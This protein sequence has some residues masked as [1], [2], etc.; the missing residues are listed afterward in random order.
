MKKNTGIWLDFKEAVIIDLE[1]GKEPAVQTL[2]SGVDTSIAKGGAGTKGKPWGPMD[3]ISENQHL[4]RRKNQESKYFQNVM[5]AVQASSELY[6]F[7]PAEAK[8][9]LLKAIKENKNFRPH[10]SAVETAD[11]MTLNQKIAQ[12][13]KFF[14]AQKTR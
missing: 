10:L 8:D 3:K 1:T 9:G 11:N 14:E 7:G 13:R 6:V 5:D 12:V 2:D 4:N